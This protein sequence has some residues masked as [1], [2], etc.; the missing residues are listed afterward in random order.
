ML[1]LRRV[2]FLLFCVLFQVIANMN[3]AYKQE[4]KKSAKRR[5]QNVPQMSYKIEAPLFGAGESPSPKKLKDSLYLSFPVETVLATEQSSSEDIK[6]ALAFHLAESDVHWW[7]QVSQETHRLSAAPCC[8]E[9]R[10]AHSRAQDG[11]CCFMLPA[12]Q[13]VERSAGSMFHVLG[14]REST[15]LKKLQRWSTWTETPKLCYP[16]FLVI[17]FFKTKAL[18]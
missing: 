10:D 15:W 6:T 8:H 14:N 4:K 2:P 16:C 9:P 1:T 7:G 18:C 3:A 11:V 12:P 17:Q 5:T 13:S